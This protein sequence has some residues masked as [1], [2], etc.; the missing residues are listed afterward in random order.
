[1]WIKLT[2]AQSRKTSG[3]V[4]ASAKQSDKKTL[5][6]NISRAAMTGVDGMD[7]DK[8]RL[9]SLLRSRATCNGKRKSPAQQ[10]APTDD[11]VMDKDAEL[12]DSLCLTCKGLKQSDMEP[13]GGLC[14]ICGETL[15]KVDV[16]G[17]P[18]EACRWISSLT[19]N[20]AATRV[21]KMRA[22]VV[23]FDDTPADGPLAAGSMN[24]GGGAGEAQDLVNHG[25]NVLDG[26][27]PGTTRR[28]VDSRQQ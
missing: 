24:A 4:Q 13:Q 26:G 20:G 19:C 28:S 10:E 22:G 5:V 2:P 23:P 14:R 8:E 25:L 1:M 17:Q 9:V 18:C 3:P 12:H 27:T 7:S 11:E 6:I 16:I 15:H 21:A